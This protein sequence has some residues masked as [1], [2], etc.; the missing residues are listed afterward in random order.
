MGKIRCPCWLFTAPPLFMFC[1]LSKS[2]RDER[3]DG[4]TQRKKAH[5]PSMGRHRVHDRRSLNN[6]DEN[7]YTHIYI[8]THM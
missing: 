1:N 7:G 3:E 6:L 5:P 4:E 8:Y 2:Q